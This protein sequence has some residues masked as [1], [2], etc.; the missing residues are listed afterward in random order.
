MLLQIKTYSTSENEVQIC[1][2]SPH[3]FVLE[4]QRRLLPDWNVAISHIILILQQSSVSLENSTS[5]VT[6]EKNRLR[7]EF[8]RFGCDLIFSL[9]EIGYPSDLFDPRTGYPLLAESGITLDDNAV[10]KALLNYPVVSH[11]QC[12]LLIHPEW[13]YN[14][15]PSTIVT[16]A[17]LDSLKCCIEQTTANR[18]WVIKSDAFLSRLAIGS[19]VSDRLDEQAI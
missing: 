10:V 5:K 14:I 7:A 3:Q 12:S 9:K 16:S 13:K 8:I 6:Q 18:N 4:H 15:Y 11:R 19:Q 17:P 1:I 2:A